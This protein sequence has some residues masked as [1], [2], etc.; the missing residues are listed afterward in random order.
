MNDNDWMHADMTGW[1]VLITGG[2]SGIGYAY[3]RIAVDNNANVTIACR[4]ENHA[5]AACMVLNGLN[6]DNKVDYLIMDMAEPDKAHDAAIKYMESHDRLD[7]LVNN[8]GGVYRKDDENARMKTWNAN[9]VSHVVLTM[10]LMPLLHSAHGCIVNMSSI[11]ARCARL[12]LHHIMEPSHIPFDSMYARAKLSLLTWNDIMSTVYPASD[13][14]FYAM[15]P[16]AVNSRFKDKMHGFQ[17][18]YMNTIFTLFGDEPAVPAR[19]IQ[20]LIMDDSTGGY[21]YDDKPAVMPS[22]SLDKNFRKTLMEYNNEFMHSF[23]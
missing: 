13:I 2:N 15:H 3:A 8:A 23:K 7:A 1:N 16:G 11:A 22:L 6:E 12:D 4:N 9:Y 10:M 5:R 18:A 21:W 19:S 14:R 20:R 17:H